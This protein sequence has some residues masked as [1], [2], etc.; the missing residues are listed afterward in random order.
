MRLIL[1]VRQAEGG[2]VM[3]RYLLN[4]FDVQT[5]DPERKRALAIYLERRKKE[6]ETSLNGVNQA[7]KVVRKKAKKVGRRIKAR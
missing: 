1:Q 3:C 2:I 4:I 7:L 6:L 5:L